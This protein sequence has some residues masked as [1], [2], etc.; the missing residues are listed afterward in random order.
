MA[1]ISA[2][3]AA[4]LLTILTIVMLPAAALADNGRQDLP[5]SS[6]PNPSARAVAPSNAAERTA[7][8]AGLPKLGKASNPYDM[9]SLRNFDAG[10][11]Q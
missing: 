11:H 7:G 8:G 6:A 1:L 2:L 10:S 4:V 5:A 3:A 9:Q